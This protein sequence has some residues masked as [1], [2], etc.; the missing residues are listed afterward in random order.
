MKDINHLFFFLLLFFS[1]ACTESSETERSFRSWEKILES[2]TLRVGTMTSPQDFYLYR[3]EPVGLEYQKIV[4]FSRTNNLLLDI[5]IARSRDSLIHWLSEGVIDICIT[6]IAM[7]KSNIDRFGFA[8]VVDT[9]SLVLVQKKASEGALV[10]SLSEMSGKDIWVERGGVGEL[11]LQQI[12]E[13][14]GE[15]IRIRSTDTLGIEEILLAMPKQDSI[16]F[17]ISDQ[18]V[19]HLIGQYY[20]TLDASL[21]ISAPIRYAWAV[22]KENS[23]LKEELDQFFLLPKRILH[24]QELKKENAHLHRFVFSE[25]K[26]PIEVQLSQGAISPYDSLFIRQAKRLPWHWTLLASIAHQE[27]NFHSDIVGWSGARGLMGIMPRT[28]KAFG[29]RVEQLLL[30]DISVQVAVDCLLAT[31]RYFQ[32]ISDPYEQLCFTLAGYNAGVGHI[33]D[34]QRLAKKYNAPDTIWF[35]GV[36][37]FVLLKSNPEYYN[38]PV[39]RNGYMR[40]RETVSYVDEVIERQRAYFAHINKNK[41]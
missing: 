15:S 25:A 41:L 4:D 10:K 34:A 22:D 33:Q 30:P 28:G 13:E 26:Q 23:V 7:T 40:G 16:N 27:S 20:P 24:Y 5:K 37:D 36:R 29:A 21:Q 9:S 35:G 18:Y 8:G 1:V 38:D 31:K 19:G 11:R 2:D 17:A 12:Q 6:P 3:G 39:V 32:N 14:I